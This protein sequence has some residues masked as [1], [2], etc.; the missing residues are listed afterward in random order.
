MS[1]LQVLFLMEK[2]PLSLQH[3]YKVS[4]DCKHE[5]P[6]AIKLFEFTSISLQ[7]MRAGNSFLFCNQKNDVFEANNVIYSSLVLRFISEYTQGKYTI[8]DIDRLSKSMKADITRDGILKVIEPFK[9]I[10]DQEFV[11]SLSTKA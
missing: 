9:D 8:V 4:M 6:L 11:E 7:Q 5:F 2:Y 3:I 10:S 1:M